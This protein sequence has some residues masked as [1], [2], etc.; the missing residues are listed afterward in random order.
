MKSTEDK[1][2]RE[3]MVDM[4]QFFIDRIDAAIESQRYIEA[5]WLIYACIENRFFRV[6]KK[7]KNQCKYC[8]GKCKK[9]RNELAISTKIS[10]VE[11]LCENNVECLSKSF[12]I[13]QINEI[14]QWVKERNKMMHE[15]LSLS[16]YEN[17][18]D[19]FKESA[20]KGQ[21][22]LSDLYKSCTEFRKIFYSDDYVF[23]FPEIAME[24]C[25]CKNSNMD[26]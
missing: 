16:T 24:G 9:N 1:K 6:L 17:M 5:S 13:D 2:E 18:D 10:C 11:R 4:H 20:I 7:Y 8:T 26:K 25:R 21:S 15:L 3:K 14:R 22:L 23:V 19:R 12:K